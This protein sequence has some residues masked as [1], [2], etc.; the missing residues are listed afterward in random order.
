MRKFGSL[1]G[2]DLF[3]VNKAIGVFDS[4]VGGLSIFLTLK[5]LLPQESFIYLADQK[6]CPYGEKTRER[7]KSLSYKN[8]Q[9][10]L[11]RGSKLIVI[12][13]N[14]ATTA[15]IDF[16][17]KKFPKVSFIGVVPVVKPAAEQSLTGHFVILST[18][19]TQKSQYLKQLISKFTKNKVIY[20]L[21]CPGLAEIIEKGKAKGKKINNLLKKY[22]KSALKDAKVDILATGCTHYPFARGVIVSLFPQKI[23]FIEPSLAVAQQVKRILKEKNIFSE[24]RRSD[25][26]FTTGLP[27]SFEKSFQRL[28]G[29]KIEAKKVKL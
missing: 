10:L 4:G 2:S 24:R 23:K 11:D 13:C 20:N 19:A 17:R 12:A 21:S 15:A 18:Q 26:F 5:K 14:T 8:T 1:V 29:F 6:N 7:I 27:C 22:L 3:M 16:L 28:I 25:K 9:F